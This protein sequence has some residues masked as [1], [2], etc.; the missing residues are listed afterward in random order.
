MSGARED[1]ALEKVEEP[2]GQV[3]SPWLTR[4]AS[5]ARSAGSLLTAA[6]TA[7][8]SLPSQSVQ[9]AE[10]KSVTLFH[11]GGEFPLAAFGLQVYDNERA[12]KLTLFALEAGI[13]NFFS[14][15]L[16]GN[17]K[18]FA[19]AVKESGI[20]RDQLY[21]CGS[22]LSNRAN[23]FDA[24]YRL[25]AR[26]C[27]ENMEEFSVGGIDYLDQIM[28]DYPGQDQG[29]ILGQW[30]AFQE[31]KEQGLTRSLSVSNFSPRQ[32]D[33][34]LRDKGTSTRPCVN[35]LPLNLAYHPGGAKAT[36]AWNN[37]REVFVQAWAP[38]GSSTGGFS[39]SIKAA[40]QKIGEKYGKSGAQIAL[41]WLI[42]SG[43]SFATSA[44]SKA[45]F[46]EDGNIFDFELDEDEMRG[47]DRL[48]GD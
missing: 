40:C 3:P 36:V 21:I 6:A 42:Q 14:S 37:E 24:A 39:R 17:Q 18:G 41:R 28:L 48:S 34:I 30:K 43:A 45:H 2:G 22:V 27:Q 29:S 9:A 20:P 16:A 31:M 26:G 38:L 1:L 46:M 5:L 32:M 23:G 11:G 15:V 25:T 8:S 10:K 19:R 44:S 7:A 47:L 33:Y 4:R 35:Q 13:R 12:R